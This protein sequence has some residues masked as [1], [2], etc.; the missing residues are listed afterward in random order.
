MSFARKCKSEKP[1]IQAIWKIRQR[2]DMNQS[3]FALFTKINPGVISRWESG[4]RIPSL[5]SHLKLLSLAKERSELTLIWQSV[6]DGLGED[7]ESVL[8][9][10]L[11]LYAEAKRAIAEEAA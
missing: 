2:L 8:V 1:L 4:Q 6:R 5:E 9:S 11:S 7:G 3:E 10:L